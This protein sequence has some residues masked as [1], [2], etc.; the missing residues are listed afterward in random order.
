MFIIIVTLFVVCSTTL[1]L[2]ILWQ[3]AFLMAIVATADLP[4]PE[5]F[6]G[7]YITTAHQIPEV[8][9]CRFCQG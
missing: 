6:A 7:E 2:S 3:C 8:D 1:M 4:F 9:S 5:A